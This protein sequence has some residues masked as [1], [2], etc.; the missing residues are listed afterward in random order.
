MCQRMGFP[1]NSIMGFGFRCVSSEIRVPR[2]PARMT[3]F[4][5]CFE[6]RRGVFE[7]YVMIATALMQLKIMANMINDG[8]YNFGRTEVLSRFATQELPN[9][10]LKVS[11]ACIVY[12]KEMVMYG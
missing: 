9:V 12:S 10:L 8:L 3:A 1:P 2:P 6:F 11:I 4:I 7:V 5:G